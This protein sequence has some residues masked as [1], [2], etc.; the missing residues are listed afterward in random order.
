MAG[1]SIA[2]QRPNKGLKRELGAKICGL[3][4]FAAMALFAPSA[5]AD[6]YEGQNDSF[7]GDEIVFA[8]EKGEPPHYRTDEMTRFGGGCGYCISGY[9]QYTCRNLL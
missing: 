9:K 7:T 3:L 5:S 6:H 2:H 1:K 8:E 4:A